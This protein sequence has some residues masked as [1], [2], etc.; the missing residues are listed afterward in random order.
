VVVIT[1]D[2]IAEITGN[3]ISQLSRLQVLDLNL[4][5]KAKGIF[6]LI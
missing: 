2:L 1:P 4:K 6:W 3:S 5:D